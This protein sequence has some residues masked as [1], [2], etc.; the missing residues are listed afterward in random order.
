MGLVNYSAGGATLAFA[1]V[2][3]CEHIPHRVWQTIGLDTDFFLDMLFHNDGEA[4]NVPEP[5]TH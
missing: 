3:T 5:S 4:F 2:G 1:V